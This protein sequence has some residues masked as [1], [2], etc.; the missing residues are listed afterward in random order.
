MVTDEIT[1]AMKDE[2]RMTFFAMANETTAVI[3]VAQ[4]SHV[5]VLYSRQRCE[6]E[7]LQV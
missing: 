4:M 2:V 7:L 5:A 1:E 6:G 3:Y